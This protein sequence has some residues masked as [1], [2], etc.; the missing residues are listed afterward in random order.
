MVAYEQFEQDLR[1][2]LA[3][4]YDP[5][6]RPS[7]LLL[8]VLGHDTEQSTESVQ[9]AL[10]Q[11][12]EGL[13]PGPQVP[14]TARIRRI[15]QL[16]SVRYLQNLCQDEAA[17]RLGITPRHLRREQQQAISVLARRLW[18]ESRTGMAGRSPAGG[19][20]SG[21]KAKSADE[22]EAAAAN[23]GRE[24]AETDPAGA[25]R[26]QVKEEVACLQRGAPGGVAAPLVVANVA[27][28][29]RS[30][31]DMA[32]ALT[33]KRGIALRLELVEPELMAAV[34]P[35]GLRAILLTGIMETARNMTS[36]DLALSARRRRGRVGISISACPAPSSRTR[37]D[38][39]RELLAAQGGALLVRESDTTAFLE[40]VLPSTEKV[41]VLVV[42]DNADLVHFYDLYT[43][44]TQY[45]I[46][47]IQEG[48]RAF[49]A[50]EDSPPGIIVL[51][52]MLPD[53]DGW[54]LLS[55][56]HAH[57]ATCSIP[58]I[59]CSVVR[60]EELAMALGAALYVAKPVRRQQFLSAL[61]QALNQ[62]AAATAP[63]RASSAATC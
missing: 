3:H 31:V 53:M 21:A 5:A 57:P 2:G 19:A 52:V 36:G 38:D 22:S 12:I 46:T 34:H 16:L 44:G 29:M 62:A 1:E 23:Q 14:A 61:D 32:R 6:Y 33:A 20:A 13:A 9:A 18:E 60:E 35:S 50:I 28:T 15:H 27:E 47:N 17:E 42:D 37:E 30:V 4:L 51:D 41:K 59:V 40:L 56:L 63:D 49:R 25:W 55:Q 45:Q 58:V 7:A 48:E 11:A 8:S 26:S 54:E 39:L 10:I 24:A 43:A